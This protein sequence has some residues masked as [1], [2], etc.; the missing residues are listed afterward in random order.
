MSQK[1]IFVNGPVNVVRLS[2][3]VGKIEKCIYVFFDYH[4]SENWQTK[5]D[6]V[7]SED[8]AKYIVDSFDKSNEKDPKLIYDFFFERGPLRPYLSNTKRKGIYLDQMS[9]LFIKSFNLDTEKKIVQK[10]L[11]VPNV[12]FHYTDVRD[13][14]IDV[15]A[16]SNILF[17]NQLYARYDLN[18]FK[19][20]YG[21]IINIGNNIIDLETII[22]ENNENPK[23][24]KI[25]FSAYKDIR[26][27]LPK[28]Y[29]DDQTKKVMYKIR[30]SYENKEIKT[31]INKIIDTDLSNLFVQ[32]V[33]ITKQCLGKLE[34]LINEHMKFEGHSPDDV[35]LQ[36]DDGTYHYGFSIA[37]KETNIMPIVS[38]IDLL[39]KILSKIGQMIMDLY[40]LRRFLDK[41]YVTN[42][43]SYTGAGHSENYVLFLVKYLGFNITHYSYLKDDIKTAQ[44]KIKKANNFYDLAILFMPP[45]LLQCS[46][47]TNFPHLFT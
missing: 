33:N 5:C 10:S 13:Y 2:G 42:A 37:Q 31:V 25:F 47:M 21:D 41:K 15:Q 1:K 24:D 9:E 39:Y 16:F 40:L 4:E 36:Q 44:G 17:N 8:V 14:V 45:L 7:R 12:R 18:N 27:E 20:V 28:K 46:D 6:D 34:K 38:D 35:L 19:R 26:H 43:L 30:N 23:I 32:Y 11:T 22:Y 29:F 3:K